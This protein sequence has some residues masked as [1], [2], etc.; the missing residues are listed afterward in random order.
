MGFRLFWGLFTKAV[1]SHCANAVAISEVKSSCDLGPTYIIVNAAHL[2]FCYPEIAD[3][4]GEKLQIHRVRGTKEI[5]RRKGYPDC[6]G[7]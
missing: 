7:A 3:L 1:Y 2:V 6:V 5:G 4:F